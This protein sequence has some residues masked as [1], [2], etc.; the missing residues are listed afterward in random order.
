[1]GRSAVWSQLKIPV[2]SMIWLLSM[3]VIVLCTYNAVPLAVYSAFGLVAIL[4]FIGS[5]RLAFFF[6]VVLTV[7]TVF[8]F[9]LFAFRDSW[10]PADQ[11]MAIGVHF[12]IL[13]HLF[14]LYSLAKYVYQFRSENYFL[15]ERI[16]RLEGFL[17]E[18][19]VLSQVEF[20][21]RASFI[22]STMARRKE[23]GYFLRV[24]LSELPRSTK[25]TAVASVGSLLHMSVRQH[26]DIVG[27]S[28]ES[29]VVLLQ[30]TD[31]TGVET[32]KCR[33]DKR[34]REAFEERAIEKMRMTTERIEG[35]TAVREG[36]LS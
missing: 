29:L 12:L 3:V 36:V 1:M 9:L 6:Y 19:G 16:L 26:F 11:G 18:E 22:L 33:I 15:R 32:V 14:A 8:L 28:G 4:F 34:L 2:A 17:S 23:T 21:K 20:E 7:G 35:Q 30:N 13:C 25:R 24:D 10:T 27:K 5:D 31:S